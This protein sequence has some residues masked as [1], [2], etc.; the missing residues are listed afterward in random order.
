[1]LPI[2]D[3]NRKFYQTLKFGGLLYTRTL[4]DQDQILQDRVDPR[5]TPSRSILSESVYW[6]ALVGENKNKVDHFQLQ[7]SVASPT[8]GL[9]TKLSIMG[10]QVQTSTI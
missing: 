3:E 4:T 2:R 8:S 1:M 7:H 9:D 5:Y 6:I 10:A